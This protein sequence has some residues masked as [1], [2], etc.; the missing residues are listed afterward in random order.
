MK[1]IDKVESFQYMF[2]ETDLMS[3]SG[4]SSFDPEELFDISSMF[5]EWA[6]FIYNKRYW[7]F[8]YK[9]PQI[10]QCLGRQILWGNQCITHEPWGGTRG[11][12]VPYGAVLCNQTS[13]ACGL[14]NSPQSTVFEGWG[15]RGNSY[16]NRV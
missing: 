16:E 13:F 4:F 7:L 3:I 2:R 5:K 9:Y 11:V 12:A 14:W 10:S 1:K 15:C 8:K 6:K